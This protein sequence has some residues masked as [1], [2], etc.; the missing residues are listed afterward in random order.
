MEL[1]Y[2]EPLHVA[3]EVFPAEPELPE[4]CREIRICDDPLNV[5]LKTN[6]VYAEK[7]GMPLH[8]HVFMPTKGA[9]DASK[10]PLVIYITGSAWLPQD[11]DQMIPDLCAFSKRGYCVASVQYRPSAVAPF[12]AQIEDVK[13]A[14]RFMRLHAAEYHADVTKTAYFGASSGGHTALFCGI[15]GDSEIL[16]AAYPE[17]SCSADAV[18]DWFG[19][20][21]FPLMNTR[22]SA[23]DHVK[24]TSPEGLLL[25]G[26][27][28]PENA[29]KADK[30]NP[31]FYLSGEKATP[32]VLIMHGDRDILVPFHQSILIY[33]RLRELRKDVEFYKLLDASHG[34][35]GF[36]STAAYDLVDEFLRRKL[37]IT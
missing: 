9:A 16:P 7:D 11:M 27:N 17:Y 26:V 31:R 32:P 21:D 6:I 19:P 3:P 10:Y 12:P 29:E 15:T 24:P 30:A 35:N 34:F 5:S 2:L 36:Q 20:T 1:P 25:G 4:G 8:L 28:V 13:T 14:M 23:M 18:V 37:R 33:E 22:P